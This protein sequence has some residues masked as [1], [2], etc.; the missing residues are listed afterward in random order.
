MPGVLKRGAQKAATEVLR[1]AGA[2]RWSAGRWP[3]AREISAEYGISVLVYPVGARVLVAAYHEGR[4]PLRKGARLGELAKHIAAWI[5]LTEDDLD[6][7][8]QTLPTSHGLLRELD[9][10]RRIQCPHKTGDAR[11]AWL[12]AHPLRH[13]GVTFQGDHGKR[14]SNSG[15]SVVARWTDYHGSDGSIFVA[16]RPAPNRTNDPERNWG[17]G[18]E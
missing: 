6:E 15:K 16:D 10:L 12:D 7:L 13:R 17:L 18:R 2:F 1:Q 14:V 4:L 5:A 3:A 8:V 11:R 9:A